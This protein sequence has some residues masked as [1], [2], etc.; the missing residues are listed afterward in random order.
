MPTTADA[1]CEMVVTAR[2]TTAHNSQ[3]ASRLGPPYDSASMAMATLPRHCER[4]EAIQGS[5]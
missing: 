5:G 1:S 3:P 4:S 2:Y